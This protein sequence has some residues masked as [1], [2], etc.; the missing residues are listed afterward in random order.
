[1]TAD[2]IL[3]LRAIETLRELSPDD[4]GEFLR[5]L[6]GIYLQDTPLR[7][8]ELD[9]A[10]A[11]QDAST[12]GRA[13]HSIKG[14]SGNFGARNFAKVAEEIERQAKTGDLTATAPLC[15]QLKADYLRVAEALTAIAQSS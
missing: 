15:L 11:K 5:E 8:A 6:I 1:M 7:L 10:L 3:D 14:S 12:L 4:G 9:E 2:Q 13:A